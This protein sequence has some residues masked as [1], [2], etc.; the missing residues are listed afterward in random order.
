VSRALVGAGFLVWVGAA[1][2]LSRW[3]RL[4]R[5][6]LT[7]RLRPFHPGSPAPGRTVRPGSVASIR[8][9]LV[10]LVG[11]AGDHLARAFGVSEGA[12]RR[13]ARIH[14]KT[15]AGA[16]RLRQA[17]VVAATAVVGGLTS[18]FTGA[19]APVALLLLVGGPILAFL[20]IE[21]GLARRSEWW[22]R[23]T[24]EELPV[25]SEQLAMLLNAGYSVGSGIN[26]L[27]A[28]G[29]GCVARDLQDVV[30]RVHQGL[31]ESGAL[32]EWGERSGVES[33]Q[34]L[35]AVLTLHGEAGDL[36]RLVSAE[37]R[38]ARRDLQ[39]RTMEQIE[40]RAQQVW[41][42][43]TV[44][45]LVPGAILLAVPFLDALQTFSRA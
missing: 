3:S 24:A 38:S 13:L 15:P 11:Q 31:S 21:R 20:V 36:G 37:A 8:D 14:S 12:A 45:T 35:V 34:R 29:H 33:V 7:E 18:V 44:A 19:P 2:L 43:V 26:R 40:R 1:L 27:A 17:V 39:R 6:S 22:Q 16:F 32:Q 23:T 28:R 25:V 30:N 5:P 9:V 42:P 10:P 41:M 4:S